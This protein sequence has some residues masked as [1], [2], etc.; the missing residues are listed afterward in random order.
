MY[1]ENLF[2]RLRELTNMLDASTEQMFKV[3]NYLYWAKINGLPLKFN[4]SSE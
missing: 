4:L 3:A 1:E 2:P